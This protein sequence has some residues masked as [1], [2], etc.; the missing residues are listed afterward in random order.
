M[1][2]SNTVTTEERVVLLY[3]CISMFVCY[4]NIFVV[5]KSHVITSSSWVRKEV[6]LVSR[7]WKL[8]ATE[9]EY[10]TYSSYTN[11]CWRIGS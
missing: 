2:N 1:E 10:C 4:K 9:C 8:W 5:F 7:V 6:E 3:E 11:F